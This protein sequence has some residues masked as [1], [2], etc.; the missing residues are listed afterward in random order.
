[1]DS[2]DPCACTTIVKGTIVPVR[3]D[4]KSG[5]GF[6]NEEWKTIVYCGLGLSGRKSSIGEKVAYA[7]SIA[8]LQLAFARQ[9]SFAARSFSC[10]E[11]DFYR[12][13]TWGTSACQR[14]SAARLA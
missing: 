1:M 7:E 13:I 5:I 4:Q 10:R 14:Q 12:P 11:L 6:R 3:L 2:Y 8:G 9:T